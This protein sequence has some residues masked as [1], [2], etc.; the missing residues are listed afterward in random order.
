[1][2]YSS[3]LFIYCFFPISLILYHITPKKLKEAQLLL[4][5]IVFCSFWGVK[6]L[7][8]VSAYVLINYSLSRLIDLLKKKSTVACFI[9]F[10]IGM[11]FD[12]FVLF[13]F[14]TERFSAVYNILHLHDG[15]FLVGISM[16]TLSALG[17]LIDVYNGRISSEKNIVRY[18]LFIMMF[19]RLLMG[20]VL[21]YDAYSRI[22]NSRK[23]GIQELGKGLTIFIKGLA[24]KVLAADTLYSLYFAVKSYDTHE[25]SAVSAWLGIIAYILC[26]YFTL[27]GIADMGVGIG[28]CFGFKFPQSFNYPMFSSR[29]RYFAAKWQVQIIHWFRNY[30]TKPFASSI[31]NSNLRKLLFIFAWTAVGVWYGF[32]VSAALWGTLM[33]IAI[34]VESS[35][36]K[37][38]MLKATGIIYTFLF[39]TVFSVFLECDTISD[40]FSFLLAMI[41]WNRSLTDTLT[42]YL[43]RSYLV[44]LLVTMYAST[45]L[46]RNMLVRSRRFALKRVFAAATPA[47]MVLLLATC[48][49]LISSEGSSGILLLRL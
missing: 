9:P 29:I 37:S 3:L 12:L 20:P 15:F 19:P 22:M 39:V 24:K 42:L 26:L 41:G 35:L 4:L 14:R 40:G 5:S 33:G 48:T 49:A 45:D 46:F 8:C 27:S 32:S 23:T 34:V 31:K 1:M 36:R 6:Y 17:Y 47:I 38:R 43:L 30:I 2:E 21:R 25:L 44:V 16:F 28:Y 7:L 11:I 13:A 18:S 10:A